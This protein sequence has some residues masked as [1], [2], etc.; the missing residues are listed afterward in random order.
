MVMEK[1]KEIRMA[2]EEAGS[3]I[4]KA[5]EEAARIKDTVSSMV[6]TLRVT[7]ER[8]IREEAEKYRRS[9]D[10][11]T[12]RKMKALERDYEGRKSLMQKE[13]SVK[14]STASESVWEM[15]KERLFDL[16]VTP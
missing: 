10:T 4:E 3:I 6:K 7:K 2:E 12:G 14:I 11:E 15:I 8:E 13:F 1:V 16:P 9:T 5:G